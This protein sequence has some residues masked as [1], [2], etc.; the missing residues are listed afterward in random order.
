MITHRGT[1]TLHTARLTLRRFTAA[2]AGAMF[3]NWA[4]DDEV[5]RYLTWP[6]HGSVDI[7]AMIIADWEK[8][9]ARDDFYQWA[10]EFE[11]EVIG[12]ISVVS[13]NDS[14]EKMEIGYCMGKAWWHRGIMSESLA[15]VIGYLFDEVGVQRIESRHDPRNPHSGGVMR[16]CGM[17]FEGTHRR[18]DRNNQGICDASTY[19]ILRDER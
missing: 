1:Q 8:N 7:S 2:D 11:G 5:T 18:A 19:A 17:K 4:G 16:K 6:T 15:A 12:S 9:Y 13:Q 3:R 10:I 14:V